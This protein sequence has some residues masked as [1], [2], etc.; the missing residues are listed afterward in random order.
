M[1]KIQQKRILL[2]YNNNNDKIIFNNINFIYSNNFKYSMKMG[3]WGSVHA[4]FDIF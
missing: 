3:I 1:R 2:S 4:D